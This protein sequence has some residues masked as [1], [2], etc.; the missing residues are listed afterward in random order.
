[1]SHETTMAESPKGKNILYQPDSL[2]PAKKFPAGN[3]VYGSHKQIYQDL[4]IVMQISKAKFPVYLV[5]SKITK[6]TYAMK[7]FGHSNNEPHLYFK[8]ESRFASLQHPNVIRNLY[9]ESHRKSRL[10]NVEKQISYIITE[11]AINGDFFSFV[12]KNR[13]QI[14]EKLAR[15]YFRQLIEGLEYIHQNGVAHMDLKLDNLLVGNDYNLKIA[16][17]D[18]AHY[19]DDAIIIGNGTRNYR[20]PEV[21]KGKCNN[22]KAA[23]IFS[24][25]IVLFALKTQGGFPHLETK[26]EGG[27]QFPELLE[28]DPTQFWNEHCKNLRQ[29]ETYFDQDFK[30]LFSNMTKSDPKDRAT[31]ENIKA[32][33][34]YNGP[35]YSP[36]ELK[37]RVERILSY[38]QFLTTIWEPSL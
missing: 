8:N 17:F 34:W 33:K 3:V 36:D 5:Q 15:T 22:P 20:G 1:M 28:T 7:V 25:A 26:T 14:D 4:D 32:S 18:M 38:D 37:E 24:A 2:P 13:K 29:Q 19:K 31:I 23:D 12:K 16:D 35:H 6:K 27:L 9:F 21:I 11:Y 10:D 30:E